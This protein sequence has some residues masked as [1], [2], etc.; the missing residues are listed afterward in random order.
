MDLSTTY[1][2]IKLKN[3]VIIGSSSLTNDITKI[4]KLAD[5]NAAAVVLKSLFEEQILA[6]TENNI[7]QNI[8][9]DPTAIDYI[10]GYTRDSEINEYLKLIS[11]AKE[12]VDIPIFASINCTTASEWISFAGKMEEA[13]ADAIELNISILPSDE[14][15]DSEKNENKYF[16]IIEKVRG[17]VSIPI[18]LKMSYYS[19]GLARLIQ[20]LS[21]TKHI[22]GFVLFNKFYNPDIDINKF[23]VVPSNVFSSPEDIYTSLRWIALLS[24]KVEIDLVASTGI[25]NA[26]GVI[27][28]I[29]AGAV[30]VQMVSAIYKHGGEYIGKILEEIKT[31]IQQ[32]KFSKL[33]D[34]KG[35]MSY[36]QAQNP[37]VYERIQ[38][39]KY[40]GGIN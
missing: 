11:D 30:A 28:Q 23:K 35:K 12:T 24:D 26:E 25:H 18:A 33:T 1:M 32:N 16:K 20:K 37:A 7:R 34:F 10:S 15:I 21:W 2:G 13:G 4:K 40:Y 38:F 31:W 27:K 6:D 14:N 22:D 39:M 9:D 36:N 29:L 3:P 8:V 5:N 19:A 17:K